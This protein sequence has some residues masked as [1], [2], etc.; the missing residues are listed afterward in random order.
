[1]LVW[2]HTQHD[3]GLVDQGH[4]AKPDGYADIQLPKPKISAL[5][6]DT[7]FHPAAWVCQGW[8]AVTARRLVLEMAVSAFCS[9]RYIHVAA[10]HDG[11]TL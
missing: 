2:I 10:C 9:G 7:G 5:C 11:F 8:N 6:R 3:A 4:A 1:M